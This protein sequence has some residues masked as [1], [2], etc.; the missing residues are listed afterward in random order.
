MNITAL[1]VLTYIAYCFRIGTL[2]WRY[3]QLNARYFS[4]EHGIFS[5]LVLDQLTPERWRLPQHIDGP[6]LQPDSFPVFLKPEWGQNARGIHRADNLEQLNLL[7]RKLA[8]EPQRYLLQE[9][10]P[11]S[12]EFEIFGIDIDRDDETH[13]VLT[14]TE[15]VNS[16][17]AFPIN[18][19]FNQQTRYVEI[20]DEFSAEEHSIMSGYLSTLGKF[21]I[22][23]LSQGAWSFKL[24]AFASWLNGLRCTP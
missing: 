3:F 8:S 23:R 2:P 24:D 15:A 10:A 11:G 17:E 19:K 12:C 22:S 21:G 6:D 1:M 18:S 7:R 9:A 5:K 16:S 4:R 13:D 14:V 20:T